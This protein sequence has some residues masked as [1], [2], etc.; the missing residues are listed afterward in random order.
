MILLEVQSGLEMQEQGYNIIDKRWLVDDF[1]WE[2]EEFFQD[3]Y[4]WYLPGHNFQ[5][6]HSSTTVWG[7]LF[8]DIWLQLKM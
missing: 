3:I 1:V 8:I 5:V 7:L 2:A 4:G 6:S